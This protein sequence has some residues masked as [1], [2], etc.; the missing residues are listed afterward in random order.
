MPNWMPIIECTARRSFFRFYFYYTLNVIQVPFFT[1]LV[2]SNQ[3]TKFSM[4]S[5]NAPFEHVDLIYFYYFESKLEI[6]TYDEYKVTS[7]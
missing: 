2:T 3:L 6:L 5:D 7:Y 4:R 1:K